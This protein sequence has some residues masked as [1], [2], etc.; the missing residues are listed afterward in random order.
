[1]QKID[2]SWMD[3]GIMS[4]WLFLHIPPFLCIKGSHWLK[5]KRRKR[6]LYGI[7]FQ[8]LGKYVFFLCSFRYFWLKQYKY[9]IKET[10]IYITLA[11]VCNI[12]IDHG[13]VGK[14][15]RCKSLLIVEEQVGWDVNLFNCCQFLQIICPYFQKGWWNALD[16]DQDLMM[17]DGHS[18]DEQIQKGS[19]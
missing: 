9:Q 14:L 16:F 17:A 11:P 4:L 18:N 1:M 7:T 15:A 13:L 10:Q 3:I 5:H 12:C 19:Q 8:Q 6:Q 2:A